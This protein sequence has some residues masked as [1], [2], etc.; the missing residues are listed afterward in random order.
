MPAT[1]LCSSG[2]TLHC[3]HHQ[4]HDIATPFY[5]G[6]GSRY[7]RAT[8]HLIYTEHPHTN[9]DNTVIDMDISQ[10]LEYSHLTLGPDKDIWKQ[11]W[12]TTLAR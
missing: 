11:A 4:R 6:T 5:P 1:A 3:G 10:S 9:H 12:Q 7:E 8:R 2:A